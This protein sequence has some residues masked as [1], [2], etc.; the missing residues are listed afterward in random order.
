MIPYFR[1]VQTAERSLVIR[2]A[3]DPDELEI[4]VEALDPRGLLLL[5]MVQDL[6]EVGRLRLIVGM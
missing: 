6:D 2:G 4:L 1:Q 5:M 3:F